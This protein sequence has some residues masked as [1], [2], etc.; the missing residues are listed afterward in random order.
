MPEQTT[1]IERPRT[2]EPSDRDVVLTK[3]D[4]PA[5]GRK[6]RIIVPIVVIVLLI[7]AVFGIRY[8]TFAAHHVSTDDAQISGDITNISPKVKGQIQQV[9]V[10]ENQSVRKGDMLVKIDDRDYAAAVAQAQA[11]VAQARSGQ[12]AAVEA[13]PL[14]NSLTGAQVA[15]AEA[16][17]SQASGGVAAAE[18]RVANVR[19]AAEAAREKIALAQAQQSAAQA[20]LTKAGHDLAR[21][22]TLVAQGAISREQFDAAQAGYSTALANADAAALGVAV[23]RAGTQQAQQDITQAQAAADQA[24]AQ[25]SAGNAQLAQ[26]Q[27]GSGQSA[28]KT[29]QAQTSGA[30]VQA[31]EAALAAAQLQL[32]YTAIRA[33]VDGIVSKKSVNPGDTI[34]IGQPLLALANQRSLW[35][36]AN[37]KETQLGKVRI[38]QPVQFKVDAYPHQTFSGKV[39]SISPATGVTFAL[40]P[41][42]NASGNFTKVV[43]RVPVRIAIDTRSDPQHMLRQGLSV[44]VSIDTSSR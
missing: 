27:T 29:A 36:T 19:A 43:Q 5:R 23:A 38:G 6:R 1:T 20:A 32:S 37:L 44:S 28:I 41:P 30:Q 42:D 15:Q 12:Q 2:A 8:F 10:H 16:G 11:G 22:K 3:D 34:A 18:A 33:P 24:R 17:I 13:V 14:Q 40:I 31:A 26:A 7:A 25:I 4:A 39:D 9:Y 21:S 35:I